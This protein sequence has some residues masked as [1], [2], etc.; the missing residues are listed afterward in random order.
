MT[1]KFYSYSIIAT[2]I[3]VDMGDLSLWRFT[4]A[5][6]PG[7]TLLYNYI[8]K[9]WNNTL[10]VPK[11]DG[12]AIVND[13]VSSSASS[14]KVPFM[15][16]ASGPVKYVDFQKVPIRNN[17]LKEAFYGNSNIVNVTNINDSVSSM[18][19]TFYN[20]KNLVGPI[21]LPKAL[22]G[23]MDS[24]FHQCNRLKGSY[25]IPQGVTSLTRTFANCSNISSVP[26]IPNTVIGMTEAFYGCKNLS[27]DIYVYS[28]ELT[29]YSVN[30]TF[31]G[32]N[33]SLPKNVYIYYNYAN[34]AETKTHAAVVRDYVNRWQGRYGVTVYNMGVAP[35]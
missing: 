8:G 7:H 2:S 28:T 30:G 15:Y 19:G 32:T 27:G 1:M 9:D 33:S 6:I 23:N 11:V 20:C 25:S 10:F 12:K 22:K 3:T 14:G 21:V 35:W 24:A 4:N 34:G 31:N 26:Y 17:S 16:D 18:Q 5:D 13:Y 29:N